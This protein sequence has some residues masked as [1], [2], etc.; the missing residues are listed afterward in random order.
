MEK[1]KLGKLLLISGIALVCAIFAYNSYEHGIEMAYLEGSYAAIG[2][3]ICERFELGPLNDGYCD[4]S[5]GPNNYTALLNC[6]W[7]NL[8]VNISTPEMSLGDKL[9]YHL[10]RCELEVIKNERT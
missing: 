1:K 7:G 6:S 3:G 5:N 9:T 2:D 8:M 4:T 10:Y